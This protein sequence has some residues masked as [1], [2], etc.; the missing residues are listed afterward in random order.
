TLEIRLS[1]AIPYLPQILAHPVM[2]P[3]PRKVINTAD[4]K[5]TSP[6]NF[7]GNGAYK[8]QK[9]V[10]NERIVVEGNKY[11][12]DN[13]KTVIDEVTFLPI[14]SETAEVNRYRSGELDITANVSVE[15][16][17]KLK[18]EIPDEIKTSP[19]LCTYYYGINNQ[20]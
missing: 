18:Q 7:V 17:P 3:V 14:A 1:E 20:R 11:Y 10:V 15:L 16:Y 13:D 8:L 4:S 5:W 12:W 6:E 9:W 19:Y 2:S